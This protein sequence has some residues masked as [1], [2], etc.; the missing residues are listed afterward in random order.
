[1]GGGARPGDNAGHCVLSLVVGEVEVS[2]FEASG[3]IDGSLPQDIG[4]LS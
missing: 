3:I 1:M 2:P 4:A